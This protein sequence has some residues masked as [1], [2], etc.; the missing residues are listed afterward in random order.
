MICSCLLRDARA[1]PSYVE[2][3]IRRRCKLLPMGLDDGDA[4]GCAAASV[5]AIVGA[6]WRL[7]CA[8]VS[9]VVACG[10]GSIELESHSRQPRRVGALARSAR[11]ARVGPSLRSSLSTSSTSGHALVASMGIHIGADVRAA[12]RQWRGRARLN[13]H[14]SKTRD[15][16]SGAGPPGCRVEVPCRHPRLSVY[17]VEFASKY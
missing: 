12:R 1:P 17:C 11:C 7:A 3:G 6:A 14:G 2:Y 16:Q 5:A 15:E 9:T 8:L 4:D 13:D 10:A